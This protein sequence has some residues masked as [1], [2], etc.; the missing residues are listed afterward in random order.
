MLCRAG[1]RNLRSLRFIS[2][3]R[4][5]GLE[6]AIKTV[7]RGRIH[8]ERPG[9][10]VVLDRGG[11]VAPVHRTDAVGILLQHVTG[12][13]RRLSDGGGVG[14]GQEDSQRWCPRS[15]H[16]V[17]RPETTGDGVIAAGHCRARVRLAD[18]AT[19]GINA[20]RARAAAAINGVSINGK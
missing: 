18:G 3:V 19:G 1:R 20:A 11:D 15:L 17:E 14:S 9:R 8:D 6:E 13:K 7:A 12:R 5:S 4:G 16:G 10:S 2:L